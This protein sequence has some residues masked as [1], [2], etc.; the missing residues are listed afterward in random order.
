[1]KE[2]SNKFVVLR[3]LFNGFASIRNL[4]IEYCKKNKLNLVVIYNNKR[5]T[6]PYKKLVSHEFSLHKKRIRSKFEDKAY[7]LIDFKFIPD[8]AKPIGYQT[9]IGTRFRRSGIPF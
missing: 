1:M 4:T 9:D 6:I 7:Y 8:G 3:K 5:M 2:G